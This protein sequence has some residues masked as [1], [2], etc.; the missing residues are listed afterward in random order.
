MF[1]VVRTAI[2]PASI[3]GAVRREVAAIDPSMAV[4]RLQPMNDW[5]GQSLAT[6]RFTTTLL[7]GFAVVALLLSV[8]G[9][10]WGG[11]VHR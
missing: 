4:A 10:Y 8:V 2:E 5:V 1:T 7:T 11:L 6:D 9:L 3:M